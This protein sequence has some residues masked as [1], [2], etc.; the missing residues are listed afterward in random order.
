[1]VPS[2]PDADVALDY[3]GSTHN[4]ATVIVALCRGE[5]RLVFCESRRQVEEF[6]VALCGR[7]VET[8]VCH[9]SLS[10]D[11]R[12]RAETAFAEARDC[13]IVSTLDA[14]AGHRRRC[15]DRMLQIDS[16]RTV[17]AFLQRLGRT[18]RRAGTT[19]KALFL[20]TRRTALTQAAG[21][22]HLW[23][24]GWVEPVTPP[25]SPQHRITHQLL[26]LCLQEH[27]VADQMW[28]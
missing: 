24:T 18:G 3:V 7:E 1:M 2:G 21:L 14:R 28:Q 15:L 25:P 16:P 11:E 26:V 19:C 4:A 22:L 13:V 20:T 5:K 12:R 9:S 17:E 6:A 10:V 8:Y 27:T 23:G